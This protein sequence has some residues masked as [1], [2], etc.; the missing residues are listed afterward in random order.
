MMTVTRSVKILAQQGRILRILIVEDDLDLREI[1]SAR[2]EMEGCEVAV[3]PNGITALHM[4]K[5]HRFDVVITDLRMPNGHGM[6]LLESIQQLEPPR[7]A[8]IVMS[9]F[10]ETSPQDII[11]RG[12]SALLV[13][14]FQL[15][16]V[17]NAVSEALKK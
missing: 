15:N 10:P 9:G 2:F 12:A 7:P 17:L 13:K 8:V 11:A 16:D 14:P 5:E 1:I 3:A 4:L 6:E